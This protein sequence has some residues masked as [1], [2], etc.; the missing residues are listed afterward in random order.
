MSSSS[1]CQ[2]NA[3]K[4][5]NV[6][7]CRRP[8]KARDDVNTDSSDNIYDTSAEYDDDCRP[9]HGSC[10]ERKRCLK[11]IAR[12]KTLEAYNVDTCLLSYKPRL[13]TV[14]SKRYPT[15]DS[16]FENLDKN[17]GGYVILLKQG[18]HV[19]NTLICE[20]VDKLTILGDC[21]PFAGIPFIQTCRNFSTIETDPCTCGVSEAEVGR[22]P[23][24]ISVSGRR[25]TVTGTTNPCFNTLCAGRNIIFV[26]ADGSSLTTTLVNA[27]GNSFLVRDDL[28]LSQGFRLGE[29]F[30]VAPNVTITTDCNTIRI[31]P[32]EILNIEGIFWTA[33]A[34]LGTNGIVLRSSRSVFATPIQIF[35]NYNFIMPNV[36]LDFVRLAPASRGRARRQAI[37]G[38]NARL[39]AE[40][41]A[42]SAWEYSIFSSSNNGVTLNN[43]SIIDF[44]SSDFVNCCTGILARC[45]SVANLQAAFFCNNLVGAMAHYGS[46][47]TSYFI[48]EPAPPILAIQFI[49][50][51]FAYVLDWRSNGIFPNAIYQANDRFMILDGFLFDTPSS[52]GIGTYGQ[53]Q[54]LII[55]GENPVIVDMSSFQCTAPRPAQLA[56]A[57]IFNG[58]LGANGNQSYPGIASTSSTT[59]PGVN[60]PVTNILTRV[61]FTLRELQEA[62]IQR[63]NTGIITSVATV[64]NNGISAPISA[65]G[66]TSTNGCNVDIG[67]VSIGTGVV[68]VSIIA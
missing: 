17:K 67:N 6:G 18:T 61:P 35:G 66:F 59:L 5:K 28:G 27:S 64:T 43:G 39:Y 57:S 24:S 47:L 51:G 63:E 12:V 9:K 33:P 20:D 46:T 3:C 49:T 58:I 44:F 60:I 19:L 38:K 1:D 37:L 36:F 11:E 25:I 54:S 7:T 52:V 13:I 22:G 65:S 48:D 42:T 16:A 21:C 15:I 32:T 50:N 2:Q 34:Q 40:G 68:P 29:G 8:R 14:P 26:R 55:Q 53:R 56:D 62:R 45:S 30:F 41:V 4:N 10:A 31:D 23:Y